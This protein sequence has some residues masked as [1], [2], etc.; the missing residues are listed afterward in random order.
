MGAWTSSWAVDLKNDQGT[1]DINWKMWRVPH[2]EAWLQLPEQADLLR[3][4]TDRFQ[5]S[6]AN[7]IAKEMRDGTT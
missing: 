2:M 4:L 7:Q 6:G 3:Q 5:T 1:S